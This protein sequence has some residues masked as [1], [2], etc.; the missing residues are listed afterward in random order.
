MIEK[1]M[2]SPEIWRI[3][4]DLPQNPLRSLNSY[5]I[6]DSGEALIVD[7]G[8]NRPECRAV[9]WD[10]LEKLQVDLTHASLFLTHLHSDHIGLVQ[11]FI[12]RGCPI[13]M[14]EIDHRYFCESA[15]GDVWPY[16]ENL[17]RMEGFPAE[18]LAMQATHN[19]GRRYAPDQAFEARPVR[20]GDTLRVG[21]LRFRCIHTPGHTPGN[22]V[23]YLPEE[24][25]LFSGDHILFDI[26]PNISV[27]KNVPHS[28]ADYL[29]SL[30][31]VQALPVRRTFPAHRGGERDV[32]ERIA[33]ILEHHAQRLE[34]IQAVVRRSPGAD[35][36]TIASKIRWS[37]RG[38]PWTQFP[39][40]QK[41]FAVGETMAHLYY[42]ADTGAVRRETAQ[43][44]VRY[45]AAVSFL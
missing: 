43:G 6:R 22:M 29:A 16:M 45:F 5:V 10:G 41:W 2:D 13:Y 23:L 7:T 18:E 37:A 8:F 19:Q 28:L 42:L 14:N 36:H 24:R 32:H 35:A 31:K 30:K 17:F 26:T 3:Q 34:E 4:V 21:R 40:H 25:L 1:L 44:H 38:T 33:E 39:P 12:D 20:D 11:D 27:W 15:A 9:L